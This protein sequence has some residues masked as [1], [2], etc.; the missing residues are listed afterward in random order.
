MTPADIIL[1]LVIALSIG[2][3]IYYHA[4]DHSADNAVN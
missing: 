3:A 2:G 4:A 1:I